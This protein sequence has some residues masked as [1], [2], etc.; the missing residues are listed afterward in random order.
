MALVYNLSFAL[1][2][3]TLGASALTVGAMQR[4]LTLFSLLLFIVYI[5]AR[6]T[7]SKRP[8]T[9]HSHGLLPH[10]A[11]AYREARRAAPECFGN[12]EPSVR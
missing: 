12:G 3:L 8:D 7:M 9:Y 6:M 1:G 4:Y 11:A 5:G 2:G 10:V